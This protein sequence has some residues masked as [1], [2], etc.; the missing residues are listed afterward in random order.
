MKKLL[1]GLLFLGS[2]SAFASDKVKAFAVCE[3]IDEEGLSTQRVV[4][5]GN[6]NSMDLYYFN[7]GTLENDWG[8]VSYHE[9]NIK[10][11][12]SKDIWSYT[13]EPDGIIY[14]SKYDNIINLNIYVGDRAPEAYLWGRAVA[15]IRYGK[16]PVLKCEHDVLVDLKLK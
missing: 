4:L 5:V 14:S 6:I 3:D 9:K 10:I 7:K 8:S 11:K 15:Q 1:F 13:I 16:L 2:F 12:N